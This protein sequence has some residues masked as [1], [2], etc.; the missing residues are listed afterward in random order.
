MRMGMSWDGDEMKRGDEEE[1]V[2]GKGYWKRMEANA[3][4]CW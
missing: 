1:R 3:C 4:D 2:W